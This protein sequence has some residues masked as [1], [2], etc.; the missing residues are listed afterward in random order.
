M[1]WTF[2]DDFKIQVGVRHCYG[3]LDV[4]TSCPLELFYEHYLV[5]VSDSSDN[6]LE[7]LRCWKSGLEVKGLRV[8]PNTKL[9]ISGPNLG[10]LKDTGKHPCG[11]CIK[12][13][14]AN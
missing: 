11:V 12:V 5:I 4:R 10:S 2:S 13:V 6:C 8:M 1:A 9:M 14:G 3:G 7:N